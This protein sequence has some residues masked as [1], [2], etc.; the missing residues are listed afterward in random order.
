M[1]GFFNGANAV[2]Y[3]CDYWYFQTFIFF[4]SGNWLLASGILF[5]ISH[6]SSLISHLS[7]LIS[8]LSS[9]N[10]HLSTLISHLST[11]ISQISF[12]H[13]YFILQKM[14][15]FGRLTMTLNLLSPWACRKTCYLIQNP[16]SKIQHLQLMCNNIDYW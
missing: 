8:Q 11:H 13:S 7:S 9:L 10:S 14:Y 6:L 1:N 15:G 4:A 5:N 2:I 3:Y 16:T 12:H